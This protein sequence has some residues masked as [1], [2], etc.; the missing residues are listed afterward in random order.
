MPRAGLLAHSR[1]LGSRTVT[2]S[3]E[4]HSFKPQH[5]VSSIATNSSVLEMRKL[6]QDEGRWSGQSGSPVSAQV[7]MTQGTWAGSNNAGPGVTERPLLLAWDRGYCHA[8]SRLKCIRLRGFDSVTSSRSARQMNC[9]HTCSIRIPSSPIVWCWPKPNLKP[10]TGRGESSPTGLQN[11]PCW[12]NVLTPS[13]LLFLHLYNT[14]L[15][16]NLL[17]RAGTQVWDRT[18]SN[19]KLAGVRIAEDVG[20]RP[21]NCWLSKFVSK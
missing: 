1:A 14:V 2:T 11:Q 6:R 13:C 7:N 9:H 16:F 21:W 17:L 15:G 4:H 5:Q 8:H 19:P 12:R 20:R 3:P 10:R 18:V